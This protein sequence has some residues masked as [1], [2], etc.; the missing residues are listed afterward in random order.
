MKRS[1]ILLLV[2]LLA[3]LVACEYSTAPTG[4]G[5]D[6]H[7]N[8]PGDTLGIYTLSS[9]GTPFF[10]G[11]LI[12]HDTACFPGFVVPNTKRCPSAGSV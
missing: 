5:R 10:C 8:Y 4:N 1:R 11:Y 9:N 6:P 7:C 3:I 12:A 2:P